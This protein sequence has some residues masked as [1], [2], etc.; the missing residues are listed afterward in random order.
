M[1]DFTNN[2]NKNIV[3]EERVEELAI[4]SDVDTLASI[5]SVEMDESRTDISRWLKRPRRGS[6]SESETGS[7]GDGEGDL[8]AS[9][10]RSNTASKRGRGRPPTTGKYVGMAKARKELAAAKKAAEKEEQLT[11]EEAAVAEKTRKVSASRISKLSESSLSSVI[12]VDDLHARQ[13]DGRIQNAVGAI[14]EVAKLSK[15]LKGT[16]QKALKEAAASITE[17]AQELLQRTSNEEVRRLEAANTRLEAANT[18]LE[19][20]M[21]ELLKELGELRKELFNQRKNEAGPPP[22]ARLS[23]SEESKV[24][25]LLKTEISSLSSR[26]SVIE[27]RLLR[28][29]LA[30]DRV[31][32]PRAPTPP[33]TYAANTAV[34]KLE[35]PMD[36]ELVTVTAKATPSPQVAPAAKKTKKK[37]KKKKKKQNTP[38]AKITA[39]STLQPKDGGWET[40]G[41]KKI[42]KKANKK[43]RTAAVQSDK[44]KKRKLR[45]PRST[46]VMITLQ[47]GAEEKGLSYASILTQAKISIKLEELGIEGIRCRETVTG[48]RLLQIPGASSGP[49]ADALAEKLRTSFPSDDVK[50]SRPSIRVNVRLSGLDD[51]VTLDEV[52]AAVARSEPGAHSTQSPPPTIMYDTTPESPAPPN[53]VRRL[54]LDTD[55]QPKKQRI[56]ASTNSVR[57]I[58]IERRDRDPS[59]LAPSPKSPQPART[60]ENRTVEARYWLKQA[61]CQLGLARNLKTE[62]KTQATL[63]IERLYQLVKESEHQRLPEVEGVASLAAPAPEKPGQIAGDLMTKMAEHSELLKAAAVQIGELKEALNDQRRIN[64]APVAEGHNGQEL[65]AEVQELKSATREIGRQVSEMRAEVPSYAEVLSK[66]KSAGRVA[67][68]KHSVVVSSSD[69]I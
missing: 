30:A 35:A 69:L 38:E 7:S 12:E 24:I 53:A 64:A 2:K 15:G 57:R 39:P 58:Q 1:E 32:V 17:V 11:K 52:R 66:P 20:Q 42:A 16:S 22:P 36:D 27:G 41:T 61:K 63:A 55:K 62:I 43:A 18:R 25:R 45:P 9:T 56:A 19:A 37:K 50:V 14:K 65:L 46:A 48:A 60:F 6:R 31:V 33:L 54:F 4:V 8:A 47:P 49:K 59:E 51:S 68:P 40:V 10:V 26:F 34:T 13:L 23:S 29:P 3:E 5:E 28:P 21:A 44:I 67:R